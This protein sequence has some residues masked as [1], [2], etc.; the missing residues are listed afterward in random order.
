M[1]G[2]SDASAWI[3]AHDGRKLLGMVVAL[4]GVVLLA[5][6]TISSHDTREFVQNSRR[7]RGTVIALDSGRTQPT[8]QFMAAP[9]N[10]VVFVAGGWSFHR[11]G[12]TVNVRFL[13]VDARGS[14]ELDE[15][16]AL[17]P[18]TAA[19]GGLGAAVLVFGLLFWA[20]ARR[21][22]TIVSKPAAG[23]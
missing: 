16:G 20:R 15:L 11:V 12:D 6:A 18:V 1:S 4:A 7:A 3:A 5:A 23:A 22:D 17:W 21:R 9:G 10:S 19:L 13:E 2:S 8:V 14:A